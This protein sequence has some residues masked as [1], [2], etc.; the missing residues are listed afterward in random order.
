MGAGLKS[1]MGSIGT[2]PGQE[3]EFSL[4]RVT[5]AGTLGRADVELR[6]QGQP[7]DSGPVDIGNR[8][9]YA[10]GEWWAESVTWFNGCQLPNF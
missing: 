10:D 1:L 2:E 5:A 3:V 8:W 9:V 6:N 4:L 7:I